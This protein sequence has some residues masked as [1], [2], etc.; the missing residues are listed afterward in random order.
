M[1][2]EHKSTEKLMQST[3]D[4]NTITSI[5]WQAEGELHMKTE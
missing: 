2:M 3:K 5:E 4:I 1:I